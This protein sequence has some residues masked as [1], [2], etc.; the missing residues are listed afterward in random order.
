MY[1]LTNVTDFAIYTQFMAIWLLINK[2][3]S[4]RSA[5]LILIQFTYLH[6]L[7]TYAWLYLLYTAGI[8]FE[9]GL[10]SF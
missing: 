1:L 6:I 8:H 10:L 4:G 2:F 3:S 9:A 7:Y 5:D